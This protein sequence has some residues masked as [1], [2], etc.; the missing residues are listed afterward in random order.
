MPRS[1]PLR[2][3]LTRAHPA[4]LNCYAVVMA[5]LAYFAMYGLRKPFAAATYESLRF[6]GTQ[7]ELKT[8]L[9]VSQ[10]LGYAAAKVFGVKFCSE[11]ERSRR[12]IQ[13]IAI[14]VAAELAL[15]AFAVV[16]PAW[17]ALAL[18]ANGFPLGL[19]WGLMVRY[20]EGR[21]TSEFL[22]AGLSC[23][24]IVASGVVKDVGRAL[25]AGDAPLGITTLQFPLAISEFWMPAAAGAVFLPLF[26]V[27]VLL[28]DQIPEPSAADVAA[29]AVRTT[30]DSEDRRRFFRRFWPGL[31]MLI[32]VYVCLT[33]FRDFRDNYTVDVFKDLHYDYEQN[34]TTI[35]KMELIV[36]LGVMPIM[37]GMFLIRDNRRGLAVLFGVMIAGMAMI[38]AATM[39]VQSQ[40][41]SGLA[42]MLLLGLGAYL[43]YVPYN[44]MLFDRLIAS[45]RV[46]GT[47]VFAIYVADS[48][49]YCGS[50]GVLLFKDVAAA[51]NSRY[52]FLARL[53]YILAVSGVILLSASCWYFLRSRPLEEK[54]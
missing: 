33:A 49:G 29:R 6:A 19:I 17:K 39:L 51:A 18:F 36:A 24:F 44:A 23:S 7:F 52:E 4:V 48:L 38:G 25:L 50:I 26:V 8:V 42:W 3:Y 46:A 27:A 37:G 22:L 54:T 41:I 1:N 31:A 43:V 30:M 45:T 16:P 5:F 14:I 34:K 2:E 32:A 21:R 35:S 12:A 10:I 20:L 11:A 53:A 9:V 47:A 40:H 28:L 13:L 15:V